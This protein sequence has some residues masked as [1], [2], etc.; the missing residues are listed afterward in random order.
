MCG[1]EAASAPL[2]S[3]AAWPEGLRA[4]P[5]AVLPVR[6]DEPQLVLGRQLNK[7]LAEAVAPL[8]IK[9]PWLA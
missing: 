8:G 5:H 6:D 1:I 4:A 9:P 2:R 3:S 7:A